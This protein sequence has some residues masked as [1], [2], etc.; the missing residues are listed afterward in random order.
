MSAIGFGQKVTG[1]GDKPTQYLVTNGKNSGSGT[2]L[3]AIQSANAANGRATEIVIKT[4]IDPNLDL[5][6]KLVVRAQN[7]TIRAEGGA[8]I[9]RNRLSFDCTTADNIL[10]KDL[11]FDSDGLGDP[12]DTILIDATKGRGDKGFWIDHCS[13]EAYFDL[14]ITSNAN[15]LPNGQPPL[16]ITISNCWFHDRNPGGPGTRNHGGL[17]ISGADGNKKTNAYATVYRNYF[18]NVRRRTP[19]SSGL[20]FVHAFNNV[21]E[22][23]GNGDPNADP[24]TDQVDGMAVGNFGTIVAEANYF[25][26]GRFK[27]TINVAG[28]PQKGTLFVG[29]GTRVN[30]Y[31]NGAINPLPGAPPDPTSELE[32]R[33]KAALGTGT[34]VPQRDPITGKLSETIKRE[35]GPRTLRVIQAVYGGKEETLDVT[36]DVQNLV[37]GETYSFTANNATL[38]SPKGSNKHFAMTY[39]AGSKLYTF[40]CKENEKVTLRKTP[41][42][43]GNFQVIAA[44]YGA[45]NPSI[46]GAGSRDVTDIVQQLLDSNTSTTYKLKPTN[47]LFGDPFGGPRKNFGM[48]YVNLGNPGVKKAIASDENQEVTVS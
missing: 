22:N 14:N 34:A 17:G 27:P 2:L 6:N 37:N 35:A 12:R 39:T 44:A 48:V 45:I 9:N 38:G 16:L 46:P 11:R 21:L 19:R 8:V 29:T 42:P 47:Q 24:G 4:D 26:A 36:V 1:G 32:T 5:Q 43:V 7:L 18:Q 40:A 33:Y 3:E 13:F 23:W 25:D 30:M 41:I 10:L 20:T 31:L 15:D 28:E